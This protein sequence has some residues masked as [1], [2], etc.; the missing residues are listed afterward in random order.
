M[1]IY[2][3]EKGPQENFKSSADNHEFNERDKLKYGSD[4]MHNYVGV[5]IGINEASLSKV[6]KEIIT[7]E[8]NF[9]KERKQLN[10]KEL[11][12][13]KVLGNSV[14]NTGIS[15]MKKRELEFYIN[16]LDIISRYEIKS[17]IYVVN[18]VSNLVSSKLRNWILDVSELDRRIEPYGLKFTLTDFYEVEGTKEEIN[19]LVSKSSTVYS[20]L[21]ETR[22]HLRE[23][24]RKNKNNHRM[25]VRQI[26]VYK[27][28]I[29]II[30]KYINVKTKNI[31]YRETTFNWDQVSF[32]ISLW[33]DELK[34]SSNSILYLDEG[35]PIKPFNT[36][37]LSIIPN[38]HSEELVGIRIADYVSVLFGKLLQLLLD[39]TRYDREQPTKLKLLDTSFF[40][41][42]ELQFRLVN[43]LY[44]FL[45][46]NG[47]RY[48]VILDCY[49]KDA[50]RL[51]SYLEYFSI[52][53][54]FTVYKSIPLI[55]HQRNENDRLLTLLSKREKLYSNQYRQILKCYGNLRN[56]I[57]L[58]Q[59][60]DI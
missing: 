54:D 27:D 5:A 8:E 14:F 31:G 22:K 52:Y 57:E 55:Q 9:K 56:G 42:N 41:L 44:N 1:N 36:L 30:D 25:M 24:V 6:E 35:M 53:D 48:S 43:K 37:N 19:M 46:E 51:K 16:L 7:L 17:C 38:N 15:S 40:D 18:K 47:Q 26:P 39:E 34:I 33:M 10:G 21:K 32:E 13:T 60:M 28:L 45:F 12:G 58:G 59:V 2:F 20:L 11:K 23:F 4:R 49:C 3:D 29:K 50:I